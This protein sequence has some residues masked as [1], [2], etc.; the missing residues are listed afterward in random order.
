MKNVFAQQFGLEGAEG[1]EAGESVDQTIELAVAELPEEVA[2]NAELEDLDEAIETTADAADALEQVAEFIEAKQEDGGMSEDTAQA[3]E[4]AVE[5]LLLPF[6]GH[7]K[8]KMP[9][10]ESFGSTGGRASATAFALEGVTDT[11]KTMWQAIKD[12]VKKWVGKMVE[13]FSA[14]FSAAGR[15]EKAGKALSDKARA[16][17]GEQTE[18]TV[19]VSSSV[20]KNV[21]TTA[22]KGKTTSI[23]AF[24]KEV[25][26]AYRDESVKALKDINKALV[27]S[28]K[29]ITAESTAAQIDAKL[30]NFSNF[31]SKMNSKDGYYT[32]KVDELAFGNRVIQV[33]VSKSPTDATKILS[34]EATLGELNENLK[35]YTDEKRDLTAW[36]KG[37]IESAGDAVAKAGKFIREASKLVKQDKEIADKIIAH[38]DKV[39]AQVEKKADGSKAIKN[40]LHATSKVA[41]VDMKLDSMKVTYLMQIAKA[42]LAFGHKCIA[43]VKLDA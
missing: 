40:M 21:C 18:S 19:E 25:A 27:A 37:E 42:H 5:A 41:T 32:A 33:K 4:M 34:M 10:M 30:P 28:V 12:F 43:T 23:D 31:E 1:V 15:L 13:W 39:A 2:V 17:Q 29:E 35:S 9:A 36:K 22:S 20:Y 8:V 26:G 24:E 3:V 7:L 11:I 6:K 14:N 16:A 38:M